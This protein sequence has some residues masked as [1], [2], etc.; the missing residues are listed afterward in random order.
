MNEVSA[1][2]H[3]CAQ[4]SWRDE[5]LLTGLSEAMR[6]GAELRRGT[7]KDYALAC[8]SLRRLGFCPWDGTLRPIVIELRFRLRRQFWRPVDL[9]FVLRFVSEFGLQGLPGLGFQ[10]SSLA[11]ELQE[12]AENRLGDMKHLELAHF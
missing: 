7:V 9:V 5:H 3:S 8:Q 10:G 6:C 11:R 4:I 12:R 1:I 2:L